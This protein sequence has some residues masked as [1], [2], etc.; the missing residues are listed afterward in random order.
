[1]VVLVVFSF[2]SSAGS[3]FWVAMV[4]LLELIRSLLE[5]LLNLDLG[6][7][8]HFGISHP[9]CGCPVSVEFSG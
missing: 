3:L 4:L 6:L 1:M 8:T 2:D 7:E 5:L 9:S